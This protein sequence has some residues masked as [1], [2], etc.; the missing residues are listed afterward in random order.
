MKRII[1]NA[2]D[3]GL[4][5][6]IN[7]GIIKAYR[8]GVLTSASLMVNM[9]GFENAVNFLK[10]NS[11]L[12][13]GLHINLFRGK[14][15]IPFCEIRTLT[16]ENGSFLQSVFKIVKRIYQK[17]LSLFELEL[18][19]DAQMKKALDSGIKITHIDSEKHLHLL[20]HVYKIV[21]KLARKYGINK[22]RNINEYPYIARFM[23][24]RNHILNSSLCK[25]MALQVL[26][27][28]V[29]KINYINYINSTDY[30]FGLLGSMTLN[31]YERLFNYLKDGTTEILC[32]PG[33]IDE[34]WRRPPLNRERYYV[35]INRE[36]E[37]S[38]LLSPVLK[39]MIRKLNIELVNHKEL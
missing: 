22:I 24:D 1:I 26:S 27:M 34:D 5:D 28:R 15:L 19:C 31:K 30:S 33:Y 6:S 36:E 35:N 20:S 12:D 39:E 2:D 25:A 32:H 4:S 37:L 9:P 21:V 38:A 16:D 29:K 10:N 11:G 17:K 7:Q 8:E 13:I 14:P 23:L 18:E 3:F